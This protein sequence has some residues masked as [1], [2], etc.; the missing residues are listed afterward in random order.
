MQYEKTG[1]LLNCVLVLGV[2]SKRS[3]HRN[4]AVGFGLT[5]VSAVLC[6]LP[7]TL[8]RCCQGTR[9]PNMI[10][11]LFIRDNGT[12]KLLAPASV[13]LPDPGINQH[14]TR[15]PESSRYA[16]PLSAAVVEIQQHDE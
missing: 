3:F 13:K 2:V 16:G 11:Y 5:V 15:I 7:F 14:T 1:S 6:V 9:L 4:R 10:P 12:A 8:N